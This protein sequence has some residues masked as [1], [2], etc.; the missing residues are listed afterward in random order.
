MKRD[1]HEAATAVTPPAEPALDDLIEDRTEDGVFRVRRE[2]FTDP[3]IFEWEMKHIWEGTWLFLGLENQ[4]AQPHDFFTTMMGRQPVLVSRG[5]EGH[6]G[7]F[8][9]SCRHRGT[10]VC[11]SRQG[12]RR[13]H[14]CRYHG[15]TF[16]SSGRCLGVAQA[17]DGQ[18]PPAFNAENHHLTPIARVESYRGFIFG[19]LNADVPSLQEHLGEAAR[20]LDLVVDQSAGGVEYVPGEVSYT[21][22]GNWKLQFENG[23]DYYHF[24]STHAAYLDVMNHRVRTQAAPPPRT[25]EEEDVAEA[26]G[27]YA[28]QHGHALMYAIRK[29]GRVHVRPLANDPGAMEEIR[30]RVGEINAKWMLR[31]RNLTIFP[32]LQIVDIS[33]QQLRTWRPLAPGKTEM[34]THCLAPV[35]EGDDARAMRIRNYE[36]F[37]NP[38]GLGSSDDNLMYEYVQSGY[39]AT[40]AGVTQGYARGLGQ[41]LLADDPFSKELD[42]Q[43][44][45]WAYGPISFG[46]ETCFHTGYREWKRLIAQGL[47]RTKTIAIQP[48]ATDTANT[49]ATE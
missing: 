46:D 48:V 25:Y 49:G 16:D 13:V 43:P 10:I 29:Q 37:F 5:V 19:S 31:Q 4:I 2:V 26:A 45:S 28:F 40:A 1:P 18:Y 35:G 21:Y 20:F 6:I 39:E 24:A 3:H 7:A 14:V 33:S 22:D 23:L 12:N 47:A 15:W 41:P 32:N 30:G 36:D 34:T 11:P 8:L 44:E 9:N 42:I 38:T 27:S 17:K